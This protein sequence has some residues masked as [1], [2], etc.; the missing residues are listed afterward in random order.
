MT[1]N[2]VLHITLPWLI[3]A[4]G[5]AAW[6]LVVQAFA[7]PGY[8]L[9]SPIAVANALVTYWDAILHHG[10]RTLA[11]TLTGFLLALAG[12]VIIGGVV[13]TWPLAY[14]GLYPL[15]IGF[16]SVPK[17]ALLPI[18]IIWFGAG[19]VPAIICS[20]LLGFFP[21]VVNFAT[22]IA[23]TEPELEDVLRSLRA[24]R[25]QIFLK[26]SIPR[27]LPYLF[28]AMRVSLTLA[29]VG[30]IT[31]ETIASSRGIGYLMITAASRFD[32]PLVFAGLMFSAA[33]GILMYS[34]CLLLERQLT[35][36]AFR[37]SGPMT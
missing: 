25:H 32:V 19:T 33:L 7:I 5:I 36:W 6:E 20:F 1:A 30:S 15:L 9:P 27:S 23:T 31:A 8:I 16:N 37:Q 2:R 4:A 28:A 14:S 11:T 29:F 17:V 34:F 35:G 21:I 3:L 12:G 24:R 10:T 26:V 22:G 18:L 13:G